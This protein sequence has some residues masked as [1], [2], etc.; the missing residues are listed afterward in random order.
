[1]RLSPEQVKQ[2]LLHSDRE[3]RSEAAYYFSR[4]YSRDSTVLPLVIQAIKQFGW[5][6]AFESY[7]FLEDL[8]QTDATLLWFIGKLEALENPANEDQVSTVS[9]CRKVLRH[10]DPEL[11][12]K[13]AAAFEGRIALDELTL[14]VNAE[15]TRLFQTPPDQLWDEF[16]AQCLSFDDAEKVPDSE[17][18]RTNRIVEAISRHRDRFCE[19]VLAIL[20][21]DF[22]DYD[23]W[24]EIYAVEL[25]GNMQ[26]TAAIPL[27]VGKLPMADDWLTEEGPRALTKIGTPELVVQHLRQ[28]YPEGDAAFRTT[29]ASILENLH[30]DECVAA[31]L[32]LLPGETDPFGQAMLLQA[33]LTQFSTDAIEPAR[34]YVLATPLDPDVLEVRSLLITACKLLDLRF[35]EFDAWLADS[36]HDRTF[37]KQWHA[38]HF[39]AGS[40]DEMDAILGEWETED[41]DDVLFDPEQDDYTETET[42]LRS[43][44]RVGRNEPCPCGSGKKY[45]K[46]CYRREE[47]VET[48]LANAAAIGAISYRKPPQFPIGTVALY[49]PNDKTT[50]KIVASVIVREDAQPILRRFVGTRIADNPK[51]RRQIAEFFEE[52][53]VK[54]V[55]ATENNLGCPHEEGEDF[56]V[57]EDCPFCPFWAGM[58]GSGQ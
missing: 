52:H 28:Q 37:R 36:E 15:R 9:I 54:S 19:R 57:G 13:H 50:T 51:V 3:I 45:K 17:I 4:S 41:D 46:C 55:A 39:G 30:C 43:P 11:L 53:R 6:Q 38:D 25:A 48:D 24:R 2:G 21:G 23:N 49:G 5:E 31:C 56:P 33:A 35:P 12:L 10:V 34:Q 32:E 58:Q 22:E 27:I 20:R 16:N 14:K 40:V 44:P 18:E 42:A 29:V 26:L 8:V 47:G 1:M 7:S